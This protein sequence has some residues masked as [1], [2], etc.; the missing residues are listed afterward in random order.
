[1]LLSAVDPISEYATGIPLHLL[2][3]HAIG[4]EKKTIIFMIRLVNTLI[5]QRTFF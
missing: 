4:T 1:M 5:D 3:W 2:N